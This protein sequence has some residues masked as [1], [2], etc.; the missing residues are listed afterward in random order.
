MN[1]NKNANKRGF[2]LIE[3]VIVM[4]VIGTLSAIVSPMLNTQGM[5]NIYFKDQTLGLMRF[6]HQIALS[7]RTT[8]QVRTDNCTDPSGRAALC[9][10]V[11]L[12]DSSGNYT[13]A[14]TTPTAPLVITNAANVSALTNVVPTFNPQGG[15]LNCPVAGTCTSPVTFKLNNETIT[16]DSFSGYIYEK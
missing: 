10:L 12:P 8:V 14:V 5:D 15:C 7:S 9:V 1:R 11:F 3:M 4:V 6:A 13:V 16:I 2:S